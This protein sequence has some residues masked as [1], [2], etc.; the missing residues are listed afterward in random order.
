V[1]WRRT[2]PSE[3]P[4][5]QRCYVRLHWRDT[6]P[7]PIVEKVM[8][9]LKNSDAIVRERQDVRKLLGGLL[10]RINLPPIWL[11]N[12]LSSGLLSYLD[13]C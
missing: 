10:K 11:L 2:Q 6:T 5:R 13:F 1:L 7:Q 4:L 9:D 3:V 8:V 12:N